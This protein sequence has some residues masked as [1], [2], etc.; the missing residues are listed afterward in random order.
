MASRS[1][2]TPLPPRCPLFPLQPPVGLSGPL[3]EG[4]YALE[5]ARFLNG[6]NLLPNALALFL[7]RKL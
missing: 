3:A 4:D 7:E 1:T 6:M 2:P 5:L